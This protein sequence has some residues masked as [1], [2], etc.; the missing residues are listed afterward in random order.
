MVDFYTFMKGFMSIYPKYQGRPL[1]IFG[2]GLAG[3]FVP[4]L[5]MVIH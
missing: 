2:E 1:F 3:H 4:L 5:A